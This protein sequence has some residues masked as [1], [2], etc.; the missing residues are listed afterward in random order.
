MSL[1]ALDFR[2]ASPTTDAVGTRRPLA[3]YAPLLAAALAIAAGLVAVNNLPVGGFFDDA[4]Y[5][6]LA[7][8]LATGHGYRNLNLPGAPLATHYPPGYPLF[9]A[10]LWRLWPTFP[11]NVML[12]KFANVAFLGVIAAYAYRLGRERMGLGL[13]AALVATVAGTATT[14]A[15]YLSSMVLSEPMFLALTLP[16]LLWAERTIARDKRDVVSALSL[17]ACAGLLFLIRAQAVAAIAAIAVVY[18]LRRRWKE[19]GVTLSAAIVV[20]LPWLLWVAAHDGTV[21]TLMRGDYGSYFGWFMDGIHQRGPGMIIEAVRR[22]LPE[23]LEHLSRRLRPP[24][25]PIPNAATSLCAVLLGAVGAARLVRRAPVTL[26]FLVTYLGVVAV[27]PFPPARFLL[28]IWILLMLVLV[29]GARMLWEASL[30]VARWRGERSR[31]TL[32]LL[33]GAASFVLVAGT[34]AYNV[35]GYQRRWWATTEEQSAR[36]VVPKVAWARANIDTSSVI[37]TDHDEGSVYLYSGRR[38]IPVTTFTAAEYF[39]PRDSSA[40]A[41]V[42]RTLVTHFQPDYVMLSGARLR[43]A[44]AAVSTTGEP[45]GV[46]A[47][48]GAAWVFRLR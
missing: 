42:L 3:S 40:D 12:F 13:G 26:G 19:S 10:A 33:G 35:R 21:P 30:P 14:P 11:A 23:M 2:R 17:G 18:A 1:P 5:V 22:N 41:V 44:A 24:S 48:G 28:G 20:A 45:L 7:K 43:G 8:S 29:C 16:L 32:R 6:I 39:S 25:N 46:A 47:R 4:F 34:I 27:W 9:L 36:W 31:L 37:A 15:L 38:S